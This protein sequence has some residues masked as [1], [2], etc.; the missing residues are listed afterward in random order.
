M[1]RF[2]RDTT[3]ILTREEVI[4]VITTTAPIGGLAR[5]RAAVVAASRALGPGPERVPRTGSV[6]AAGSAAGAR[7]AEPPPERTVGGAGS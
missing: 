7:T 4:E 1:S 3:H 5:V 6:D 2:L